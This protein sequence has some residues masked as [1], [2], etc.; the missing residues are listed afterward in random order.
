MA[1]TAADRAQKAL[2]AGTLEQRTRIIEAIRQIKQTLP[3]ALVSGGVSNISFSF[4]GNNHVREAM[5]D[6][7]PTAWS[8]P[9][10]REIVPG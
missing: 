1:V 9:W 4:R 7:Q 6:G 8:P 10:I 5:H 3:Q 2:V